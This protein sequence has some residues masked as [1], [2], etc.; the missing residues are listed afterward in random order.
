MSERD[1]TKLITEY[2][3]HE[4]RRRDRLSL[5]DYYQISEYS[6]GRTIDMTINAFKVGFILGYRKGKN[7]EKINQKEHRQNEY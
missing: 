4:K 2:E 7:T 1:I 3:N 5:S 6:Q